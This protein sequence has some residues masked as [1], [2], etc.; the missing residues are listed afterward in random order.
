MN[1][2]LNRDLLV[3]NLFLSSGLR[4]NLSCFSLY[5]LPPRCLTVTTGK[6]ICRV[7]VSIMSPTSCS[8]PTAC[9]KNTRALMDN[10]YA[11]LSRDYSSRRCSTK[12]SFEQEA[13]SLYVAEKS[14]FSTKAQKSSCFVGW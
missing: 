7:H 10:H 11:W 14:K 6:P 5:L 8:P 12:C 2:Y 1:T 4:R 13:L 3:S 9:V